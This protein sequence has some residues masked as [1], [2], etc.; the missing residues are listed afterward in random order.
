MEEEEITVYLVALAY[1]G[2]CSD[3]RKFPS[4]DIDYLRKCLVNHCGIKEKN[5]KVLQDVLLKGLKHNFDTIIMDQ[6]LEM[7]L[8]AKK[9]VSLLFYMSGHGFYD[10]ERDGISICAG[11]DVNGAPCF[12][13]D[14]DLKR[15]LEGVKEG[16]HINLF[17]TFVILDRL[18]LMPFSNILKLTIVQN[19]I[20]F[21]IKVTPWERYLPHVTPVRGLLM[22]FSCK[23]WDQSYQFLLGHLCK[24]SP[25]LVLI[26]N[27]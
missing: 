22:L 20:V 1:P 27:L 26:S 4:N 16:V 25:S 5:I 8:N 24:F 21:P 13:L 19:Q 12:I 15:F 14:S 18:S 9:G 7:T 3:L 17:L 2:S 11:F 6:L 23:S 10:K